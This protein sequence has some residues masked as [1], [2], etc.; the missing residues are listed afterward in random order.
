MLATTSTTTYLYFYYDDYYLHP[1]FAGLRVLSRHTPAITDRNPKSGLELC[2][3]VIRV[4]Y[5]DRPNIL[6]R[7]GVPGG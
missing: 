3:R 1:E 6:Q 7:L 2:P 4:N 5:F